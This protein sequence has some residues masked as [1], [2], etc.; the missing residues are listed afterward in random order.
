MLIGV[1][2]GFSPFI[3][4]VQLWGS[5]EGFQ[6]GFSFCLR[7]VTNCE[8]VTLQARSDI[9]PGLNPFDI[10]SGG[11]GCLSFGRK[12]DARVNRGNKEEII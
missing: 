10:F 8:K 1:N 9:I 5:L 12:D 11:T 7:L 3:V 2:R 6:D 4:A